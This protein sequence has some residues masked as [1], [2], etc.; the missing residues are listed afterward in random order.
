M[1]NF[2]RSMAKKSIESPGLGRAVIIILLPSVLALVIAL[3]VGVSVDFGSLAFNGFLEIVGWFLSAL[4]LYAL[5]HLVK[6]KAVSGKF[7]GML[8]GLAYR[9]LF[10]FFLALLVFIVLFLIVPE[11]FSLV[12]NVQ[13]AQSAEEAFSIL[14]ENIAA[15]NAAKSGLVLLSGFGLILLATIVTIFLVLFLVFQLIAFSGPGSARQNILILIVWVVLQA[16]VFSFL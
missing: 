6:G 5:V 15:L 7:R 11:F 16:L 10:L 8:S 13:G 12:V 4:V 3:V 14:G 1:L 9:N 2:V